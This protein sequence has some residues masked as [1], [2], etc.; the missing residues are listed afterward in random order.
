MMH[1]KIEKDEVHPYST[2]SQFL[3]FP[4]RQQ[5]VFLKDILNRSHSWTPLDSTDKLDSLYNHWIYLSTDL[6]CP[7]L[8][9]RS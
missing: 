5:L 6:L 7:P 8:R 3:I 1:N 2:C 4:F 9:I